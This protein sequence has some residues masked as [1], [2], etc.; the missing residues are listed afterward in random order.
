MAL[1]E[2]LVGRGLLEIAK[3]FLELVSKDLD[4]HTSKKGEVKIEGNSVVLLTPSHIQW[5]KYGR[6][7][8]KQPP[9]DILLDYVK[10]GNIKFDGLDSEG[11]AWA[12]AASIAKKGT[13]N[14]KRGAPNALEESITKS[15]ESYNKKLAQMLTVEIDD[16]LQQT[17]T[18]II[19]E[20]IKK[21]KI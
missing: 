18:E 13:K 12:M 10:K 8:G 7:P 14:W 20:G 11:T 2:A 16:Q 19:P 9:I 5:A 3:E 6:G 15:F 4:K 17:F 1:S 21:Y